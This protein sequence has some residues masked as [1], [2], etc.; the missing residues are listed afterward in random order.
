[1]CAQMCEITGK[2]PGET[3]LLSFVNTLSPTLVVSHMIL[4]VKL[5]F[6]SFFEIF[7]SFL[8]KRFFTVIGNLAIS[9]DQN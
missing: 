6:F 1:M 9:V 2:Y 5:R 7:L 8:G 3:G 4:L